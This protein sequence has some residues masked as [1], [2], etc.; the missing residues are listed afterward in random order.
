MKDGMRIVRSKLD[1]L[2]SR[3]T[4]SCFGKM[5]VMKDKRL[6][7]DLGCILLLGLLYL[8]LGFIGVGC[9]IKFHTGVSCL[10]CGMTRAWISVLRLRF[11]E[12][13]SFHPLWPLPLIW[14]IVF[15]CKKRFDHFN[16]W[17]FRAVNIAFIVAFVIVY[18]KRLTDPSDTIVVFEPKNG[19]IYRIAHFVMLQLEAI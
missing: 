6:L 7:Q 18:I 2:C 1:H 10:G 5:R 14:L 15:Y 3:L 11:G 9:P 13:F 8:A 17:L 4:V 12:A 16:V 19:F